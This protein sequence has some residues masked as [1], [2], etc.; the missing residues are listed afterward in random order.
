MGDAG[1]ILLGRDWLQRFFL[2]W[3]NLNRLESALALQQRELDKHV[4]VF[5]DEFGLVNGTVPKIYMNSNTPPRFCRPRTVPYALHE[6]FSQEIENLERV[7]VIKP[8]QF[9]N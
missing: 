5:Q 6:R 7:S 8:I 4:E 3:K 2:D 1:P 9:A